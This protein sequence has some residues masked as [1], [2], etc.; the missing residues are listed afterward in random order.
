ML[1]KTMKDQYITNLTHESV[2]AM[3]EKV[4]KDKD[5]NQIDEYFNEKN[6]IQKLIIKKKKELID[7]KKK[8][9]KNEGSTN[10]MNSS[11]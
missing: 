11:N 3:Q 4:N 10:Q 2:F 5:S 9:S 6:L 1:Y 7:E 8:K